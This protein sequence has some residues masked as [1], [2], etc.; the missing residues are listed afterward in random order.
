MSAT[1]T[2]N[3]TSKCQRQ[4]QGATAG[5]ATH[6]KG[7]AEQP[8]AKVD[9][10]ETNDAT[11]GAEREMRHTH[12]LSIYTRKQTIAVNKQTR[13]CGLISSYYGVFVFCY[14]FIVRSWDQILPTAAYPRAVPGLCSGHFLCENAGLPSTFPAPSLFNGE[15]KREG[16]RP[17]RGCPKRQI[18]KKP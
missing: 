4:P 15:R 17:G 10:H 13:Y 5:I 14:I 7:T 6:L 18:K 9:L 1:T 3:S 12:I 8:K 2:R 16:F 11:A